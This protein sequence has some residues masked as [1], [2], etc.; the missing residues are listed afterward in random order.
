MTMPELTADVAE[1]PR[2]EGVTLWRQIA[3]TLE[4][5]VADGRLAIGDRLPS[6]G[7]LSGR[8]AVN[9]HTVR[10]ALGELARQG[11]IRIEQGRGS[12]VAEDTLDYEVGPR[13]RLSEWVRKQN[14][15]PSGRVLDLRD[16]A[17][18]GMV[19]AVLGLKQGARVARME[20]LGL[21]DGQ[22][23]S[24][25]HHHFPLSRFPDMLAALRETE[26][27]TAALARCGVP[28]YM[29]QSTRVSARMP[30]PREAE[31][32][33]MPRSRPLLVAENVNVDRHGDVVEFGLSR[34]PTPRVQMVFEP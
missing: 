29:R 30:Q 26:T 12:F 6:E 24:L 2:G 18:D 7:Q 11:L 4:Q 17:A 31:L 21:A 10:R 8:F 20:R 28:D 19:A 25:S 27:I 22:P 3:H 16:V 14:K 13:T 5:E 1:L 32:L 34:F 15:E 23:V 33:N 9:R